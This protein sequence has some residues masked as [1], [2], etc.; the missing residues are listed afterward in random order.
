MP[1]FNSDLNIDLLERAA[2]ALRAI[3]HPMRLAILHLLREGDKLSVTEIHTQ[4][5][6]EQAVAS[7]HLNNMKNKGVLSSDRIGNKTFYFVKDAEVSKILE[8]VEACF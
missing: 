2:N 7:Y 1:S 4:L 6:I 8:Y 3:S 5:D